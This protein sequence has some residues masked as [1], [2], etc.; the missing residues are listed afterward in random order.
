MADRGLCLPFAM[1]NSNNSI[2]QFSLLAIEC[3]R[4]YVLD[5]MSRRLVRKDFIFAL[6]HHFIFIRFLYIFTD[7]IPPHLLPY[8]HFLTSHDFT[9]D[10]LLQPGYWIYLIASHHLHHTYIGATITE[11]SSIV[12]RHITHL[13]EL[14]NGNK[15]DVFNSTI[16][17]LGFHY[18]FVTPLTPVTSHVLRV[19]R[20][21]IKHFN[22]SL[23]SRHRNDLNN[24]SPSNS[25]I[26]VSHTAPRLFP[27]ST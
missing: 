7:S 13:S 27:L 23:N 4:T 11:H 21:F 1:R 26:L 10:S 15:T 24:E 5:L 16:R 9:P 18:F 6:V 17:H 2:R 25:K 12:A 14:R 3:V 22:P 19:E 20:F 8:R